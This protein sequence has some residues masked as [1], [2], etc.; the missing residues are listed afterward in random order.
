MGRPAP[1]MAIEYRELIIDFGGTGYVALYRYAGE[2]VVVL[3]IKHQ[4]EAGY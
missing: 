3:A 4:R 1:D 2:E